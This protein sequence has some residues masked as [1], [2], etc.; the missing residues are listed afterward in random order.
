ELRSNTTVELGTS[1]RK[2]NSLK[3][4]LGTIWSILPHGSSYEVETAKG[5]AGVRGTIFFL[6]ESVD[7][8]YVCD[9]DGQVDVQTP[10]AKKPNQLTSKHQ[11]KGIGVVNGIQ[12]KA[13][14][15]DHTDEQVARLLSLV[16]GGTD[17]KME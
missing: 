15:K 13:K 3:L 5:V 12:R 7:E 4:A 8:L 17:K 11:H 10:K 14:L 9:C 1:S 6:E 2:T 16:P